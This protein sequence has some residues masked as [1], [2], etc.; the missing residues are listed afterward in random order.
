[1]LSLCKYKSLKILRSYDVAHRHLVG[2]KGDSL[3]TLPHPITAPSV[4]CKK[5]TTSVRWP[6]IGHNINESLS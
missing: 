2:L 6:F 3:G 5:A 1:M 4:T